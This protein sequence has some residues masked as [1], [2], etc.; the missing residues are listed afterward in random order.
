[1]DLVHAIANCEECSWTC[2]YLNSLLL[3]GKHHKKTK[4]RVH[5]ELG[6]SHTIG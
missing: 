6:Y 4:H 5:V 3:A 1:M 2:G